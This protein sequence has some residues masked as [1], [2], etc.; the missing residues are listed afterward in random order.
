MTHNKYPVIIIGA[1]ITGLAAAHVLGKNCCVVEQEKE[2]GGLLRSFTRHGCTFDITGHWLHFRDRQIKQFVQDILGD[3]LINIERR[4]SIYSNGIT[5]PYPFQA[6]TFGRPASVIA[7]CLLGYFA[8]REKCPPADTTN[9]Q[10][11]FADFINNKLGYGFAKHFMTPYNT[12]LWTVPPNEFDARWCERFIPTPTPEE[13]IYGALEPSGAG[14]RLGYNAQFLYPKNGGIAQLV[15]K[16]KNKCTGAIYTESTVVKV[17]WN[18]QQLITA[19]GEVFEYNSLISTAPLDALINM[20]IEPPNIVI[21]AAKNLRAASVTYWDV[22]LA[23]KNQANDAHWTYYPDAEIAFYRVGS[24]SAVLPSL[25][26]GCRTLC[27]ELSHPR[28][29]NITVTTDNIIA[30]LRAVGLIAKD[31][32]PILCEQNTIEC[33]YVIMDHNYGKSRNNVFDWLK[34]NKIFSI[35]R[36]GS[37]TY[38]SM[39]GAIFEGLQTAK[40]ILINFC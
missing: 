28:G 32:T 13:V 18:K 37:W 1:G 2:V 38:D 8:A 30:S 26:P 16:L 3:N 25:A 24:P 6:N 35:G 17:D 33:A 5:T 22:V 15:K 12:K 34:N 19:N 7:D 11:S 36:Y 20:L 10:N 23:N 39:E 21:D 27:V 40:E 29:S 14:H 4:A 9:N 31:E